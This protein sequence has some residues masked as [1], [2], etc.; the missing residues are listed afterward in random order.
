M[1]NAAIRQGLTYATSTLHLLFSRTVRCLCRVQCQ[2]RFAIHAAIGFPKHLGWTS[3]FRTLQHRGACRHHASPEIDGNA[4][5]QRNHAD[6]HED[7]SDN[8]SGLSQKYDAGG[9][10]YH[11]AHPYQGENEPPKT[12]FIDFGGLKKELLHSFKPFL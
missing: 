12:E 8:L 3:A 10:K 9:S 5:K 4:D 7:S 11:Y 6:Y 1:L 2:H